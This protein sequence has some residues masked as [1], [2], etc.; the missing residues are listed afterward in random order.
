LVSTL[1]L[2]AVRQRV[3]HITGHMST[4]RDFIFVE[5]VACFLSR[6][7]LQDEAQEPKTAVLAHAKPYS[8]FEIQ[9]IVESVLGRRIYV[10]YS[11]D[12]TNREDI[13]FSPAVLPPGWQPSDL[14]SNISR[15]Y[16]QAVTSGSAFRRSI[17]TLDE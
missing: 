14:R 9:G 5:D 2:N 11:L 16:W 17:P 8:L 7:V 3:T 10:S 1:I 12:P 13:T 15:I 4:L 6:L